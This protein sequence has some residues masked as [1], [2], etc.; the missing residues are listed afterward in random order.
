MS[1]KTQKKQVSSKSRLVALLL[2]L[3]LWPAAAHRWYTD[4]PFTAILQIVTLGGF[5][6]WVLIDQILI[7]AGLF[8]DGKG[9]KVTEWSND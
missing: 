4:R 8:K 6:I 3:F 7:I 1:K 5:G 9:R 2:A